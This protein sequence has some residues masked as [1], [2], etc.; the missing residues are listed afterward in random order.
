M[1]S[2]L[3]EKYRNAYLLFY[4]RSKFYDV[5]DPEAT[6]LEPLVTPEPSIPP[7]NNVANIMAKVTEENERYWR[8]RNTFSLEYYNFLDHLWTAHQTNP[9][10]KFDLFKFICSF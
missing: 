8:S 6:T 3:R 1:M 7:P 9:E 10:L 4:E 5:S 2:N